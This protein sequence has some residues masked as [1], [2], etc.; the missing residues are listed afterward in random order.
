VVTNAMVTSRRKMPS[1]L[2]IVASK[3]AVS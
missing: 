3:G 2:F 1:D